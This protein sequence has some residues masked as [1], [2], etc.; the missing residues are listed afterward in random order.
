[1]KN[2]ARLALL[3]SLPALSAFTA[4]GKEDNLHPP[5]LIEFPHSFPEAPRPLDTN[6]AP[7]WTAGHPIAVTSEH[8]FVADRDNRELVRLDRKS[9]T[10][11]ASVALG[12]KPEQLVIADD[13]AIFVS[14][15]NGEVLRLSPGLVIEARKKLGTDVFGLALSP[16]ATTLYAT[17]PF[18]RELFTLDVADLGEIA[19]PVALLDTPRGVTASPNGWLMVVHQFAGGL[20]IPVDGDN[21]PLEN[22]AEAQLRIGN[23]AEFVE[24]LRLDGLHAARAIAAVVSPEDGS[25]FIAHITAAPGTEAS[26]LNAATS[27]PGGVQSSAAVSGDGYG[28]SSVSTAAF[29][30]P[31]RPVEATVTATDPS[32]A[33]LTPESSFPVQDVLTG[34]PM[35]ALIDQP[36]DIAHHP[37]WSLLFVTGY[38]SDNVLVMST[39]EDLADPARSPLAII[40]VGH[41]PRGIAFSPDGNTAY[42][43]NE[44]SL[45]VSAID[46]TPFFSLQVM[47]NGHPVMADGSEGFTPFAASAMEPSMDGRQATTDSRQESDLDSPRVRPFRL[48]TTK[49]VAYGVDPLPASV[50]RGARAFTF[51]RNENMSHAGEFACGTCHFEGGEDKLVWFITDGPRQTP[52]LAGRLLGTAPFNWGGTKDALKDN[53]TQTVERMRG[54]GLTQQELTDLEQFLLF[55]LEAPTNPNLAA[56][57]VLTPEQL[58]GKALF[59]DKTVGCSSCHRPEQNFT[60]GFV[61]DVGTASQVEVIR[62]QFDQAANAEAVPPWRLNTPT[63]K[64]LFH[65]APYLHDGS[66][67]T[68]RDVLDRTGETMGKTTQLTD[69]QKDQLIAYLMTL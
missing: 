19:A 63:L 55:G 68:L 62:F 23:P 39:G 47:A 14:L 31:T 11:Q 20:Q 9:L 15:R 6:R 24:R 53:M 18:E 22:T 38:G 65:T 37:T 44:H 12:G 58:A 64:G 36:S 29:P 7:A 26:F 35:T 67:H 50:R 8:I 43:V 48:S 4:C 17:L 46:L 21:L 25:A 57:G 10:R 27:A 59:A 16:D 51:A 41:A 66:A 32:G 69:V 42:V 54:K 56:D 2:V 1:M 33:T 45:T 40:D 60:D 3:L 5:S 61:H 30:I 49:S 13:G 28:G 34:E 52:A